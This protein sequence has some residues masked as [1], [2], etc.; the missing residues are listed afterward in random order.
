MAIPRH[1][2]PANKVLK[3]RLTRPVPAMKLNFV[4][5]LVLVSTARTKAEGP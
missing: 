2:T 1:H 4:V 3:R 5:S